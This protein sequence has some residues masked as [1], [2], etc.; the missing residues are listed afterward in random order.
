MIIT[1][2]TI[3]PEGIKQWVIFC[4]PN[5]PIEIPDPDLQSLAREAMAANMF[6]AKE[7]EILPVVKGDRACVLAGLG[8][9]PEAVSMRR[10]A[11]L[12]KQA[13]KTKPLTPKKPV[14]IKP[15]LDKPEAVRGIV[16]GAKLGLY[17]WKKY[18]TQKED[19]ADY[20]A[21]NILILT[22]HGDLVDTSSVI[23]DGVNLA[24][25]LANENADVADAVFLEHKIH[26]IVDS[27][28]RCRI[29]V[30]N[31]TELEEKGLRLHLAVNQG[32]NKEPKL[33]IVTYQG[34]G[35]KDP[36]AALIGKGLTFD[37]GGLNLK[38]T[39]S[40]ET[41]RMDMCGTAAVI[42]TL[43]NALRL[44]IPCNAYFVCAIAENAI[45][46][47]SYKP[48][49]VL[50]SYCGKTVEIGNTDAEGRLVLAD[51]NSYLATQYEPEVIID[52]ATLTGAV[53]IALGYEY[54]G[55]MASH[56]DLAEA[57]LNAAEFTDDRAWELP[58]YPELKDHVKSKVADI[59]NIGEPKCAGTLA[60]GEFLRQFAQC[61][62]PGQAWAHLDIAGTSKPS[63]EIA[64]FDNGATGAGVRL[65]TYYLLQRSR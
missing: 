37:T 36:Y 18:L 57:L 41:M 30:L 35:S 9:N 64:Y 2:S 46:S 26:E 51:A 28:P 44:N 43:Y 14:G 47:R 25:D 7:E 42:G 6:Q 63:K 3:P 12:T 4:Q 21:Y 50:V 27:D 16:D 8:N 48:G 59:K 11:T 20:F 23:D 15:L 31:Q 10:I 62:S 54:T 34:G 55:L 49:D 60:G 52:I 33:I 19:A 17:A 13:L 29:E 39:G 56:R 53:V 38:P 58:I 22:E 40:M 1:S 65:L 45:G 61:V 5:Q 32:S 24:R